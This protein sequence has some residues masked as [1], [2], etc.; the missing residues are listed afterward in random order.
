MYE[1]MLDRYQRANE[2]GY[3]LR[4]PARIISQARPP[5]EPDGKNGLLILAFTAFGTL[6]LGCGTAVLAELMRRG[7]DGSGEI[8]QQLGLPVDA[9]L[10]L[11]DHAPSKSPN[12]KRSRR[13][14]KEISAMVYLEAIGRLAARI[15][16]EHGHA[17]SCQVTLITS[18]VA[19]EGKSTVAVG[20]ARRLAASGKRTL[21]V[22]ADM[23]KRSLAGFAGFDDSQT[24][25]AD[26]VSLL[27][28]EDNDFRQAVVNDDRFNLDMILSVQHGVDSFGLLAGNRLGALV[29]RLRPHYDH[30]IFDSPPV[31]ALSD[32]AP[33]G[34]V[35]DQ[36]R[37]IVRWQDTRRAAVRLA[38][39]ELESIG[40]NVNG[41]VL[42]Q[43][44][45]ST[46]SRQNPDDFLSY[47]SATGEYYQKMS[48]PAPRG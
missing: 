12:H 18:A 24:P 30:V 44:H 32:Y 43:I 42:N 34:R 41:V 2:Q 26:L 31:L 6:G 3:L 10:P 47:H 36:I 5:T 21:L 33:L 37:L 38:L 14:A 25:P 17:G 7:F 40:A 8:E 35:C 46:Y 27:A 4:P 20:V 16:T 13:R 22:D 11:L 48:E 29:S 39:Q 15:D 45:M 1:D 9:S 23:H 19:H 28:N